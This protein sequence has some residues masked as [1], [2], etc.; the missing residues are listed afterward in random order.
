MKHIL[1]QML[2][3]LAIVVVCLLVLFWFVG[4]AQTPQVVVK[5]VKV[6]V[7]VRCTLTL[8]D[9]PQRPFDDTARIDMSVFTKTQLL[10]AQDQFAKAY[11]VQLRAAALGCI[12]PK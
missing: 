1:T 5:E 7:P 11:E 9:P 4:C 6:E 2:R 10:L 12:D 3:G 8:P